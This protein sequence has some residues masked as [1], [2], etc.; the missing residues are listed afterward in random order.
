[1]IHL[2]NQMKQVN[3]LSYGIKRKSRILAA[4]TSRVKYLG[5]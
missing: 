5:A 4:K 2:I 1:M 3:N